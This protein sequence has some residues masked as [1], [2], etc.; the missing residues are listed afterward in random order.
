MKCRNVIVEKQNG[1]QNA[2]MEYLFAV[3]KSL[4]T[5]L[6]FGL[7]FFHVIILATDCWNVGIILVRKNV[8][9]LLV[10]QSLAH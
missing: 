7:V 9:Q 4:I 5:N 3:V 1:K 8:I 10:S 6:M 2:E